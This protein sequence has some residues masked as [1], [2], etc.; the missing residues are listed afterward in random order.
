MH[1]PVHESPLAGHMGI[2][3]TVDAISE[4]FYFQNLS[5]TVSDFVRTCHDCQERKMTKAYTKLNIISYRTPTEPFQIW[6]VNLFGPF[7]ITQQG[8]AYI[9]TAIDMFSNVC[10]YPILIL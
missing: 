8:N 1:C 6:Q 3:Q 9:F 4:H 7:P 5:S 10:Q 2:Q